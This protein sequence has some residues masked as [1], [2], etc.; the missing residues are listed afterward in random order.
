MVG[1]TM[2]NIVRIK[3]PNG[4]EFNGLDHGNYS[5]Y[6]WVFTLRML[7]IFLGVSGSNVPYLVN[8]VYQM[9]V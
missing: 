5:V 6:F 1:V 3:Y 4:W 7:N 9:G 8:G 2:G